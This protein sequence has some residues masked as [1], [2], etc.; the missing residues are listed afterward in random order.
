MGL[1]CIIVVR[2]VCMTRR[3]LSSDVAGLV[4][5]VERGG[6]WECLG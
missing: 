3:S 4:T 5:L 6:C 2:C 1:C